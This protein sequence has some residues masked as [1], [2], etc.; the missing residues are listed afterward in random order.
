MFLSTREVIL[1]NFPSY[2]KFIIIPFFFDGI[3]GCSR[4]I[5]CEVQHANLNGVG[6]RDVLVPC[7]ADSLFRKPRVP[8]SHPPVL[9]EQPP[10]ASGMLGSYGTVTVA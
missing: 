10:R 3:H 2:A 7:L 6:N 8:S 4:A 9:G 1:S 5:D